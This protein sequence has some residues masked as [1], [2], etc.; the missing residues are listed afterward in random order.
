MLFAK[1]NN[2]EQKKIKLQSEWHSVE[3]KTELI[4]HVIKMQLSFLLV[5]I[6]EMSY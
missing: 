1:K 4:W 6:Y 3:N 5:Q 2:V